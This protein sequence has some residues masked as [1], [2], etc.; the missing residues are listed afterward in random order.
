MSHKILDLS[1]GN[2]AMWF[3]KHNPLAT[4]VDKRPE[5]Q[6]TVVADTTDLQDKVGDGYTVLVFDPPHTNFGANS[7][8]T[9][10]YGHTTG[11]GIVELIRG[12]AK[13]AWRVSAPNACMILKWNDR[14]RKLQSVLDLM[15]D[16]W[17]PQFGQIV[18]QRRRRES[19]NNLSA[20]WWVFLLKKEFPDEGGEPHLR[21][22][23]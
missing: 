6:P 18:A 1:A 5:V 10:T 16:W 2:R 7:A 19:S 12:T 9:K 17:E 3:D 11:P 8:M 13:E 20:T 15:S 21:S 14:D 4:F 23:P 22:F